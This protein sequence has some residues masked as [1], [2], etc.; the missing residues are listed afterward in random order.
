MT[1]RILPPVIAVAAALLVLAAPAG[2]EVT[3][4]TFRYG[5]ITVDGYEVKQSDFSLDVPKPDVDGFITSM[6]VDVT[7][8]DGTP[9]PISR[10]MLHHIVFSTLGRK[11]NTCD[12]YTLLDSKTKVPAVAERFNAAGEERMRL[13]LPPGYGYPVKASDR[14]LMTWMLM[15]HRKQSDA[16]YIS[17]RV[18]YDTSPSLIAAKPIWMDVR[19]CR[20][21]PVYSVPGGGRPG[22]THSVTSTWT[23]PENG[24]IIAGGGHV[25]GG[26]KSLVVSQP[27]CNNRTIAASRPTWGLRSHPFYSVRPILHEP[28][29][30]NMTGFTSRQGFPVTAGRPVKLTS[31]Y[32]AQ[33]PHTRVMGIYQMF[34]VPDASVTNACAP[35]PT[36]VRTYRSSQRG[37]SLAP[38]FTV[39]LTGLNRNGQAVTIARPPGATVNLASGSTID[40]ASHFFSRPNVRVRSGSTL[41]WR[42]G[43]QSLH[44]VTLASGPRGFASNHLNGGR[45]YAARF[46]VPGTY[47]LFCAL[48]PVSMTETVTVPM[49]ARRRRPA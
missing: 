35:F 1:R 32:D 20:A 31:N 42:F 8:A 41:R 4:K 40:V 22:S 28:G 24:R 47:K 7:D 10:L 23:P 3:E 19:N 49:P 26:G 38:R 34:F 15:N 18:T 37:R 43:S 39:P 2:A 27:G 14:W 12:K 13:R 48:H 33:L 11:D 30:I 9:V 5:P 45:T 44:N 17:Y 36:D 6:D 46:S 21:D 16:A 25:H 29:P